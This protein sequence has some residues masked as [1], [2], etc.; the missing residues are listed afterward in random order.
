MGHVGLQEPGSSSACECELTHKYFDTFRSVHT[1]AQK[2]RPKSRVLKGR[3]RR[4]STQG[5]QGCGATKPV[6]KGL[7]L[8]LRPQLTVYIQTTWECT[9]LKVGLSFFFLKHFNF[10]LQRR[11]KIRAAFF[12]HKNHLILSTTPSTTVG[13]S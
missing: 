9:P 12:I 1:E 13:E 4:K 11:C 5:R 6:V 10:L 2:A 7:L 8:Q 3:Q